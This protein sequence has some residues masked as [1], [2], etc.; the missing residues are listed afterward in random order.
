MTFTFFK[1]LLAPAAAVAVIGAP[2]MVATP[3]THAAPS[4]CSYSIDRRDVTGTCKSGSGQFRI[5][6]D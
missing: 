2:L 5:H 1:K 6:L 3:A 4:N